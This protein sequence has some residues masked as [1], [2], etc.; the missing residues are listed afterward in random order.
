MIEIVDDAVR[1]TRYFTFL[2]KTLAYVTY[3]A[4]WR[5]LPIIGKTA[6]SK[7]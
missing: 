1:L 5:L 7:K 6:I 3:D 4:N 2:G